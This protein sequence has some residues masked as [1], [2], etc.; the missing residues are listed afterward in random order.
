MGHG[1]S[2]TGL[3]G[4]SSRVTRHHRPCPA[5]ALAFLFTAVALAA[6]GIFECR[7]APE[8]GHH[9]LAADHGR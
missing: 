4:L 5:G 8:N 3:M 2:Q 9:E 7:Q 6:D 1:V